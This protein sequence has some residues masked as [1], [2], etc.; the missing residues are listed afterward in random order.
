MQQLAVGL[1]DLVYGLDHVNGDS[2]RPRLIGY[3]AGY[4]LPYP[5]CGVGRELESLCVIELVNSLDKS[6]VALLNKVEELHTSADVALCDAD[7]EPEVCL[8]Q[9]ALCGG[10]VVAYSDCKL[11]LLLGSEQRHF[12]YL[13]EIDLDGVVDSDVLIIG[14]SCG[15]SGRFGS[16]AQIEV[17]IIH[18]QH[19]QVIDYLDIL[20]LDRLIELIEILNIK[21]HVYYYRVDLLGGQFA[22]G[23]TLS[24]SF[25]RRSFFRYHP[26][27]LCLLLFMLHI[28]SVFYV[29]TQNR[30]S[31][32]FIGSEQLC[33]IVVAQFGGFYALRLIFFLFEYFYTVGALFD[34]VA[35]LSRRAEYA[36]DSSISSGVNSDE[37]KYGS[38]LPPS[39]R[40]ERMTEKMRLLSAVT[41]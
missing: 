5:P 12:A 22:C 35:Q 15:V 8:G 21:I 20:R 17:D 39:S 38:V 41:K 7:D 23:F 2:Y 16:L 40:R 24:I 26:L 28:E 36:L 37:R 11:N 9:S 13:L 4:R 27:L 31:I 33:E 1:L 3:G 14:D 34:G 18:I 29:M 32:L 19:R 6:E 30:I 10:V 25:H